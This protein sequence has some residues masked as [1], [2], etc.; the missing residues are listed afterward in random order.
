MKKAIV[1]GVV[2]PLLGAGPITIWADDQSTVAAPTDPAGP[3]AMSTP[4]MTFPLMANPGPR[5]LD[6]GPPICNSCDKSSVVDI[7]NGQIFIQKTTGLVQFFLEGGG[8]FSCPA[9]RA[10]RPLIELERQILAGPAPFP[11]GGLPFPNSHSFTKSLH[12][13][14][15]SCAF[16]NNI[17]MLR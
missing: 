8:L 5:S 7:N 15:V 12:S 1:S 14:S 13:R 17:S 11:V 6:A 16:F 10:A 9:R 2:C 3:T 4:S